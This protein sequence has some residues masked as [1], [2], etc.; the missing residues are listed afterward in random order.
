MMRS[1]IV[2]KDGDFEKRVFGVVSFENGLV[3]VDTDQGNILYINK[4]NIIFI[5]ELTGGGH[6]F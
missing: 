3:K 1:K 5:K 4:A 6:S 2:F